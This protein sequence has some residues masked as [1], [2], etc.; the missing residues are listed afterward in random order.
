MAKKPSPM[1][2]AAEKP[3]RKTLLEEIAELGPQETTQHGPGGWVLLLK[4]A[5]QGLYE[6]ITAIIVQWNADKVGAGLRLKF[7]EI[8][9]LWKF[10]EPK[11]TPL[12]GRYVEYGP[13]LKYVNRLE[14]RYGKK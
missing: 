14:S 4:D 5:D 10:L 7:P 12:V 9:Q 6:E 1:K 13:F 2:Q 3:K 8:K 11:I